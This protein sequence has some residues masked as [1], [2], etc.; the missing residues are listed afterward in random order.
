M[1]QYFPKV[2]PATDSAKSDIIRRLGNLCR[3]ERHKEIVLI[4]N[5]DQPLPLPLP[6]PHLSDAVNLKS[7]SS[8]TST[9]TVCTSAAQS[10]D[11]CSTSGV[12]RQAGSLEFDQ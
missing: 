8:T 12:P 5:T 10:T 3:N 7:I 6:L 1:H 11:S 4:V 2:Y 9:S